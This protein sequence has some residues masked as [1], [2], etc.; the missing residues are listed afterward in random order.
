MEGL[1][2]AWR[3]LRGNRLGSG[4]ERTVLW[5]QGVIDSDPALEKMIRTMVRGAWHPVGTLHM[6]REDD[7]TAVVDQHG[8]LHGCCN[9]TVADGSIMPA[10]PSVPTNLTCMLI[11]E[12]I[13]AH[14]RG[15]DIDR[16]VDY[17]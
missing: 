17:E 13:A 14:L 15:L 11:G 8:R 16:G 5:S 9:V 12:R 1:R 2:S 10:I 4:I 7:A 6:G 3:I